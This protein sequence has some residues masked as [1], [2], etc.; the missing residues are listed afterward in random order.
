MSAM[1]LQNKYTR[2]YYQIIYNAKLRGPTGYV[3]KHHIIPRSLGGTNSKDNLVAL[4]AREHFICHLMLTRMTIG[5]SKKKMVS[6]VF[7]LTGGGKAERNNRIK[8]SRTYEILRTIVSETASQQ[9][10]G[11]KRP[12]RSKE[13]LTKQSVAKQGSKNPNSVG[14]FITPWGTFE[15]SRLAS[16]S[17]PSKMSA[18]CIAN[19]CLRNNQ[20]PITFLSICRSHGYLT[21]DLVGKT[22]FDLG[23]SFKAYR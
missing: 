22:P 5:K 1:Y 10:K 8:S 20:K 16:S 7:Y 12:Q 14:Y 6:A 11:S 2:W 19:F 4:T 18:P 9:H 3:E 13:Y 23:F 17:C 15:S 21:E